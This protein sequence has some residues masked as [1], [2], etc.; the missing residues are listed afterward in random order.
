MPNQPPSAATRLLGLFERLRQLTFSQHP[1]QDSPVSMAQLTLLEWVAASPGCGVQQMAEG[2]GLSAPT[3]SVAVRRLEEAGWLQRQ[4]HPQDARAIQ[5]SLTAE[6]RALY[7]RA[8]AFQ[9]GK[10]LRLLAGLTPQESATLLALLEKAI[11]A[12]E[13][14][15]AQ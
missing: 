1:L 10:V 4:T 11:A 3:V 12:A 6:G 9:R 14:S 13:D 15:K 7:E 2:L 5:I 8:R